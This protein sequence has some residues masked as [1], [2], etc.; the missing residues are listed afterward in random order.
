MNDCSVTVIII[1]IHQMQVK[2]ETFQYSQN[3]SGQPLH[4][5]THIYNN[6]NI[7]K[8]TVKV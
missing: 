8:Y 3:T 1:K 6:N 7:Y 4:Q 5:Q 2:G